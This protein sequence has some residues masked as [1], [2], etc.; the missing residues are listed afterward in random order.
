MEFNK[1][2]IAVDD[3]AFA[4]KAARIGFALAHGLKASIGIVF[5]IDRSQEVAQPDL[6]INE[7]QQ[8][9]FL[10]QKAEETIR[11]YT[12]LYD[13]IDSIYRFTPQGDPK[14][15]IINIAR[16]WKADMIVMGTHGR[17]GL[18]KLLEGS[19]AEYVLKHAEVPVLVTPPEMK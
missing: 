2:L 18:T 3:S 11:Q 5:V 15:E 8:H 10:L 17:S 9:T 6:G 7:S 19:V 13:G 14:T 1:I 4:M 16:E 12:D